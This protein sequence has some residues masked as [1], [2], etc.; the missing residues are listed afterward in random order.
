VPDRNP[1]VAVPASSQ[2][3]KEAVSRLLEQAAKSMCPKCG[4]DV[5]AGTARCPQCH[6]VL[7][8]I[9][10]GI[11]TTLAIVMNALMAVG[12][13]LV[14]TQAPVALV[15][16]LAAVGMIAILAA[17]RK[18]R[19]WAWLAI[20]ILWVLGLVFSL[21]SALAVLPKEAET[22][23]VPFM[24]VQAIIVGLLIFY[25]NTPRVRTFCSLGARQL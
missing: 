22:V 1:V 21:V 12:S 17:A 9:L 16:A 5:A 3:E 11:I 15:F 18:G 10:F 14:A 2:N 23:I 25:F 19:Y 8:P 7:Y 13:L 24:L 6:I 20:Q 4:I